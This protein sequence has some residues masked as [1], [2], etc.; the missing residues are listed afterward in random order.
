MDLKHALN[1]ADPMSAHLGPFQSKSTGHYELSRSDILTVLGIIQ[2]RKFVGLYL[3]YAKYR[4]DI[5]AGEIALRALTQYAVEQ[6][7]NYIGKVLC[8]HGIS[9]IETLA[10]FV[11][12]EYCRTA[13]TPGAKCRCG[14]SGEVCD[15]KE[16]KRSGKVV[17][18]P[19]K[20]CHGRGLRP[21]P[22]TR[23]HHAVAALIPGVSRATWYRVWSGYYEMLLTW[24]YLQES[25]AEK[26]FHTLTSNEIK[27]ELAK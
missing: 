14:G 26:E 9:A 3:L 2:S 18:I 1:I 20:K 21:L 11:L 13:D 5:N 8:K 23:A 17:I 22:Q 16:K 27:K 7:D 10:I 25:I 19:C 4:K 12:E 24:C 15:I 6:K